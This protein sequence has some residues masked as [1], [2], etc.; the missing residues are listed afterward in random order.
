MMFHGSHL[1]SQGPYI[2]LAAVRPV[3]DWFR[4]PGASSSP[5]ST[6]SRAIGLREV[7]PEDAKAT[8]SLWSSNFDESDRELI[9]VDTNFASK[10]LSHKYHE[11]PPTRRY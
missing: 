2:A 6:A 1:R 10:Y 5:A 4:G 7:D 11:L 8:E 9:H 3:A